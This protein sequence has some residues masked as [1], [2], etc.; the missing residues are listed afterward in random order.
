MSPTAYAGD[1]GLHKRSFSVPGMC[2]GPEDVNSGLGWKPC[3]YFSKGFCKNGTTCRFVHGGD[4]A[5]G[6]APM[7]GSPGE[8]NEFE[9]CQ[10]LLRSK[11]AAFQ[12]QKLAEASMFMT[13][14]D[15]SPYNKYMNF[16]HQQNDTQR[17]VHY[18]LS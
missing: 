11:A 15:F 1:N 3:L 7:V 9:Q 4:S 12:Q 5:D 14:A 2:F 16:V 13:G 6:G 10:E 17:Y 8:F 18:T